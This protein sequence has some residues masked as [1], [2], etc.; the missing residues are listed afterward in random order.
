[1]AQGVR[2]FVS[3]EDLVAMIESGAMLAIPK[4]ES[5]PAMAATRALI[6]Q[7]VRDLRLLCAPV[8][9][10]QADLLIGAGC[11][12]SVE[13]G[14]IVINEIGVG[15]SFQRAVQ[16]GSIRLR[17]STCPA[18]HAGLQAGEKGQPF[19]AIRGLIGSDLLKIRQDWRV[20][21]NPFA[22]SGDPVVLVP[23][24]TPDVFLFHAAWGDRFGNVWIAGR[25]DLAYVAHASRRTLVTFED[26]WDGNLLEDER[27]GP[28]SLSA[29]Y[30]TALA[31]VPRGAAPM[32]LQRRYDADMDHIQEYAALA[33]TDEGFATYL[34]RFVLT[35][36]AAVPE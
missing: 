15:P 6:R 16:R 3:L 4:D 5:G 17:D 14:A 19:A 31:H 25:R 9:G 27:M 7:G 10:L 21:D 23:A 1:M 20:I 13:C 30:T 18:I 28:G 8:C 32:S 29:V 11:V 26:L 24:I 2:P 33:R 34:R 22:E 12:E 36:R 35:E